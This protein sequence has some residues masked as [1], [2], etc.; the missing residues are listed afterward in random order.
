MSD[1]V[2][3]RA[4]ESVH[5][6]ENSL[7]WSSF[8]KVHHTLESERR[9][10][11]FLLPPLGLSLY[12]RYQIMPSHQIRITMVGKWRS[13]INDNSLLDIEGLCVE[14][15]PSHTVSKQI[16]IDPPGSYTRSSAG[17]ETNGCWLYRMHWVKR[18]PS[19]WSTC[20]LA[21]W[22]AIWPQM[23]DSHPM[24]ISEVVMPTQFVASLGANTLSTAAVSRSPYLDNLFVIWYRW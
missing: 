20:F 18:T 7:S 13:C 21:Q 8:T 1:K 5:W 16:L 3:Y 19:P 22:C 24:S 2:S 23:E 12:S 11:R 15:R 10:C 9:S 14:R 17:F 6:L 4:S